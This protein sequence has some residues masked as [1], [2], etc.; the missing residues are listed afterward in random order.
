MLLCL[1][2]MDLCLKIFFYILIVTGSG[3]SMDQTSVTESTQQSTDVPQLDGTSKIPNK[4]NLSPLSDKNND[5]DSDKTLSTSS[6][7]SINSE[8][9]NSNNSTNDVDADPIVTTAP[10]VIDKAN[11][12]SNANQTDNQSIS[13]EAPNTT[14]LVD[15]TTQKVT[16][17]DQHSTTTLASIV[18]SRKWMDYFLH[19]H[20]FD[21]QYIYDGMVYFFKFLV[22]Y[23]SPTDPDYLVVSFQDEDGAYLEMN[24]TSREGNGIVFKLIRK[25]KTSLH[26][27]LY[28]PFEFT[29]FMVDYGSGVFFSGNVTKPENS[30]FGWIKMNKGLGKVITGEEAGTRT[31]IIIIIPTTVAFLGICGTIALI[32]WASKKGYLS[33]RHKSYRLFSN[34]QV[35]YESEAETIHI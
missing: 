20:H 4:D 3:E 22:Q 34:T 32:C 11:T 8:P 24:G 6:P 19:A 15:F 21:G 29:G 16:T 12:D 13:S 14:T 27:P 5:T 30:S 18:R 7:D 2:N 35:S 10:S 23:M 1:G 25:Y 33:G 17:T 31:A 28:M 26:F 9:D